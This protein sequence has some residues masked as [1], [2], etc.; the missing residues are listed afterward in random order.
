MVAAVLLGSFLIMLLINV[1]IAITMGISSLLGLM[2][3]GMSFDMIPI[4]F[5]AASSKFVLLAIPFFILGGNIM[6]K[7]GISR[8]LIDFAMALVGHLKGGLAIVCVLVSCFFAAISGSAPATVAA[9]G[10]IVIPAMVE[11]GYKKDTSSALMA[12]SGAIG[13]IIPPSITFVIYGSIAGVSISKLFMAGIIPGL[14]MG[15]FI[16]VSCLLTTRKEDIKKI[17]KVPPKQCWVAFKDAIWAILM[18]VI[19]LGGIYGG[20]CTPTEAAAIAA[21]YGL[22]V[23]IFIYKSL[24]FK[25]L[26]Q[27]LVTSTVQSAVVMFI[28]ATASLFAW[29]ITTEG[30]AAAASELLINMAGGNIIIFLLIVNIIL[31]LAGCGIDGTSAFYIFTPILL[32]V[33]I[34]LGYDPLVFGVVMV[35]N[36]AIGNATPPVGVCL[37]VACGIGNVSLKQISKASLPFLVAAVLALFVVT[38]IPSISQFIPNLLMAD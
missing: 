6:E 3:M 30:I 37:Y 20:V 24:E 17:P 34:Q 23:G 28:T 8:K 27:I 12:T 11:V 19:I 14:L 9:L 15:A 36:L 25:E 29:I 2:A 33:A 32:P 38:Y 31:L 26:Y 22:F 13:L 35:M 4:N 7:A 16:A 10:M 5:Y 1:P 21:V 18:P